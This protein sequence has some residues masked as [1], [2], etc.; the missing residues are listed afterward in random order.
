LFQRLDHK[1][2]LIY[3][4]AYLV[5]GCL[6]A[7]HIDKGMRIVEELLVISSMSSLSFY[8]PEFLRLKGD[9]VAAR[10][11]RPEAAIPLY[12]AAIVIAQEHG[13]VYYELRAATSL[14]RARAA[15]G[16]LARAPACLAESA[17]KMH[18]GHDVPVYV[19]AMQILAERADKS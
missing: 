1:T 6:R 13:A 18:E 8:E 19:E 15:L 9:L 12:E 4:S 7:G 10:A 17:A 11:G 5:E 3:G 16:D 2:S 14:A